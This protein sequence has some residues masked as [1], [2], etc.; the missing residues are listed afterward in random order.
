ME[1]PPAVRMIKSKTVSVSK[2]FKKIVQFI[3]AN[4]EERFEELSSNRACSEETIEKLRAMQ[5]AL[6]EEKASGKSAGA[7]DA[8][9][10][11][12]SQSEE[13]EKKVVSES[14]KK[15]KAS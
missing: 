10:R 8:S 15:R 7:K 4:A 14:K 6:E 12:R 5:T 3:E 9:S 11:K 2:A 13:D 1:P